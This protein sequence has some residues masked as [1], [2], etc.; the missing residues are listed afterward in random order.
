MRASNTLE[1]LEAPEKQMGGEPK[2][3][4]GCQLMGA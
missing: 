4:E 3:L 2:G 1:P